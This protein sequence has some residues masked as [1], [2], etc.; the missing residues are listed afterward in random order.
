[1]TAEQLQTYAGTYASPAFDS[2]L[3]V[4]DGSLVAQDVP[5]GGFPDKDSPPVPAEQPS[6]LAFVGHD[7]VIG[8]DPSMKGAHA[9]FLRDAAGNLEWL[10]HDGRLLRRQE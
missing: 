10:R 7:R 1:M 9:E 8:L 3:T 5:K 2:V 6:R 4:Q